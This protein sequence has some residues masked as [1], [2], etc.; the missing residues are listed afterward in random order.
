MPLR[1][2]KWS[3]GIFL[4]VILLIGLVLVLFNWN[5]LRGPIMRAVTDK[6]GRELIINGD[7]K[8]MLGWPDVRVSTSG[9]TFANPDWA[10]EKQMVTVENLDAG[11]NVPQLFRKNVILSEVSLGQAVIVLEESADG[12]RNWLL[13]RQQ[14]DEKARIQ[15]DRLTLDRARLIYD[16]PKLKT[17]IQSEIS[18]QPAADQDTDAPGITI[19]AEGIYQGLPLSA[20]GSGGSVLALRD[21]T[22]PYPLKVDGVIGRTKLQAEGTITSLIK[23]TAIDM[24]LGLSG[25]NLADLFPVLG[26]ALPKTG[27]YDTRGHLAHD[28]KMWRYE[29]FTGRIGASDIGGTLQVDTGGKR[30]FLHGALQSGVLNFADLGPVIGAKDKGP[31]EK[32]EKKEPLV[33]V[34]VAPQKSLPTGRRVLP[35]LP[36]TTER[37]DSVDADVQLK[38][39]SIRRAKELPIE[40]LD[41]H[42][43]MQDS[44]ITLDPL[45]FGVA[46]GNLSGTIMLDG[47]QDPIH[48]R[49]KI[50][51]RKLH[52][53]KLFPTLILNKTSIGHIN[54]DFD[55]SG[56]GN[57]VARILATAD[58][59]AALVIAGGEI[60]KLMME[61][62]GLHLWE[63][64]RLKIKGD[65]VIDLNCGVADFNVKNGLMRTEVLVLDTQVITIN[66]EGGIDLAQ[67]KLD[68]TLTPKTKQTRLIALRSPIYIRG[69]FSKPKAALDAGQVAARSLGAV[70]LG[71][72][73]PLLALLPL[74]ETGPGLDSDCGRLIHEAQEPADKTATK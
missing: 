38:A 53:R 13:D 43:K 18:S 25:E 3:G 23:F 65:Q 56:D 59:K 22:V 50:Q 21:E 12:R 17:T 60:S 26:V 40:N 67:E 52:L 19:A 72:V 73:N 11:V 8:V 51:A 66:A 7:L 35:E 57:S 39:K 42:L 14:R 5:W 69:S 45:K 30:P 10:K 4:G 48:A 74:V 44:V 6:T 36:F 1:I 20:R 27:P 54:G 49:A 2:L 34:E 24:D 63:M 15:I 70:A 64:L 37:W 32:K 16:N 55:L 33:T 29:N 68:L 46:G 62:A 31:K 58:G 61:A 28:A 47:Q 9:L 41:V 71:T